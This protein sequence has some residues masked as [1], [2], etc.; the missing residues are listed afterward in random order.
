MLVISARAQADLRREVEPNQ[1]AS[2]A[3]PLVPPCSV[4]G[5]ILAAGDVD[6]YALELVEGRTVTLDLLARGFRAGASAGSE[7]D[8][9]LSLIAPD[10]TTILAQDAS[11]GEF[12]DPFLS[13][14]VQQSGRH[15]VRVADLAGSGGASHRY[16]LSV[17]IEGGDPS[18]TAPLLVP[19][20]LPTIDAL[21]HPA[22]DQ[23]VYR[24]DALA[25][26]ILTVDI[27]S[28]VFNPAQPPAKIVLTV[29]DA[30]GTPIAE[31][32][33]TAA[34]P[35]DPYLQLAVPADGVVAIRVRELR[36]FVGTDNTFYQLSVTLG[37]HA[38]DGTFALASPA[39]IPRAASG[40]ISPAGDRDHVGFTLGAASLIGLDLDARE[41]LHSLLDATIALHT[42]AGPVSS[43]GSNPDPALMAP[44]GPGQASIS[45]EG[46]CTGG[47]CLPEDSYYLVYFDPDSDADALRLP[48][49]NCPSAYN[50]TQQDV[51]R[52]GLGD[53]CDN[54]PSD[55][56][57]SQADLDGDGLGDACACAAFPPRVADDLAL[58]DAASIAWSP[59]PGVDLYA[60]YRGSLEAAWAWSHVC[61]QMALSAPE[62]FEPEAP[63]AGA[64]YY[65]LVSGRGPCGE[66]GLG[67][68]SAGA[69]RPNLSP[70]P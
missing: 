6:L 42:A 15:L 57:P 66:T 3:Q 43:D 29:L 45:V 4:G 22:G 46:P 68:T 34:D 67:Q 28:A 37:P 27:D 8:P 56:N 40:T 25:G 61:R 16:V 12:D 19:P 50:P 35:E 2:L 48:A 31:D 21:I 7:L 51:D 53:V 9:V 65:F 32:A 63:A 58:S 59:S 52:D 64:G 20:V 55:F 54:C 18:S 33:Y 26:Q 30:A 44:A 23:D 24:L 13:V 17:E 47:G 36:A 62:A 69:P 11:Q 1:P 60:L 49:D 10:G 14:P 41:G 38:D 70:C 39:G 5:A